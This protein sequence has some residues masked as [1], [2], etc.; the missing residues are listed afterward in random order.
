MGWRGRVESRET[1]SRV[2]LKHPKITR[3]TNC[4]DFTIGI[5]TQIITLPSIIRRK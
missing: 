5:K 1:I 2:V 3:P 4:L